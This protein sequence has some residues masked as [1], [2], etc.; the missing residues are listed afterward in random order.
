MASAEEASSTR[1]LWPCC[2]V[3]T[4]VLL[5]I[6]VA[7]AIAQAQ[8]PT[9]FNGAAPA[10]WIAHPEAPA[11]EFGVFHF[12]RVFDLDSVPETFVVHVSADNRYRLLLSG[13][14]NSSGLQRSDLRHWR[15]ESIDLAPHLCA[16]RNVLAALVWNWGDERPVA[17]FSYRTAFLLQG[18][19]PESQ[20][21]NT[22]PAWKVF[23]NTGYAPQPG[24]LQRAD[25]RIPHPLGQIEVRLARTDGGRLGAGLTLPPGL[26][27]VFEWNG[28]EIAPTSGH[29][30]LDLRG[31]RK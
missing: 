20:V 11:D 31:D 6:I 29:Q 3:T 30:D 25:G 1:L 26:E 12:R 19:S 9:V 21:V 15:Y 16:G 23:Q 18:D 17:Q 7:P 2:I 8:G 5:A 22:G 10:P 4:W 27:G 13:T 14:P 28:E 24:P